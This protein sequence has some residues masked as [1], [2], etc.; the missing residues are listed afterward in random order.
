MFQKAT[1]ILCV[2]LLLSSCAPKKLEGENAAFAAL[3]EGCMTLDEVRTTTV[4]SLRLLEQARR[5]SRAD[6]ERMLFVALQQRARL[7]LALLE[8]QWVF[9]CFSTDPPLCGWDNASSL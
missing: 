2:G 1:G 6:E 8:C 5:G 7:Q 3:D 4:E 9:M